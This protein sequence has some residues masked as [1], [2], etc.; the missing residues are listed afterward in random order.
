MTDEIDE[1]WHLCEDFANDLSQV[2]ENIAAWR[3]WLIYVLELLDSKT[4]SPAYDAMLAD[5]RDDI[6]QRLNSGDW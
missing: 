1:M 4:S 3:E 5:L 6:Q 2:I